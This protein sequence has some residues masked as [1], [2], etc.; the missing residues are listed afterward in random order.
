MSIIILV[1]CSLYNRVL[2]IE[3]RKLYIQI[4]KINNNN[5]YCKMNN[6]CMYMYEQTLSDG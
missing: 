3:E 5:Y 6:A 4:V 1:I 2:R